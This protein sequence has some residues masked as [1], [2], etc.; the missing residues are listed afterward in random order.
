MHNAITACVLFQV[1]AAEYTG[2]YLSALQDTLDRFPPPH[3]SEAAV[4]L[5]VTVGQQQEFLL[6]HSL[7]PPPGHP[8]SLDALEV[9]PRASADGTCLFSSMC[10]HSNASLTAA[11]VL[12]AW[13][14]LC[15]CAV[16]FAVFCPNWALD[17]QVHAC[18]CVCVSVCARVRVAVFVSASRLGHMHKASYSFADHENCNSRMHAHTA[19]S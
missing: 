17:H 13:G 3:P 8:G 5:L 1:T 4:N 2:L 18:V 14:Q 10:H 12:Y 6:W 15:L 9:N 7:L 16:G 19:G 11:A